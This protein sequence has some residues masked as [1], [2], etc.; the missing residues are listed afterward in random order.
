LCLLF[1]QSLPLSAQSDLFA[2]EIKLIF[3]FQYK[4]ITVILYIVDTT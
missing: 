3:K 2:V 1:S 4:A